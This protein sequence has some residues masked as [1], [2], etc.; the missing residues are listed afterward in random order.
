MSNIPVYDLKGKA[1]GKFTLDQSYFDGKIN[2]PLLQQAV[3]MYLTNQRLATAS[4]KSRSQVRGGGRKPWRQKGTGRARVGSI[5]SPI[6]RGGGVVFGG[7]PKEFRYRLP[8]NAKNLALKMSLNAKIKDNEVVVVDKFSPDIAKTKHFFGTLEAL[9]VKEAPLVVLEKHNLQ[10]WQAA[11]NIRGLSI[12]AFNN[13]NA[14][15]VLRH[16]KI[17]F[18]KQALENLVKLRKQ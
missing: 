2:K 7:Q 12:K 13:I 9:K 17:V 3:L 5:R 4:N 10:L 15:D 14:L 6:W 11:R 16:K 8:K 1:A 18:S